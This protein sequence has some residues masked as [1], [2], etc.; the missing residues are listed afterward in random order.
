MQTQSRS[1]KHP[2]QREDVQN[3]P[4]PKTPAVREVLSWRIAQKYFLD[5]EFGHA[6]ISGQTNVLATT[7]DFAGIAFLTDRRLWSPI[8]SRLRI[9][10]SPR[11]EAEWNLDYDFKKG[12]I[13]SSTAIVSYHFGDFTVGGS[14]NLLRTLPVA[15]SKPGVKLSPMDLVRVPPP[16]TL[17]KLSPADYHQFRVLLGYGSATK[18]GWSALT[19]FGFDANAG[20]LQYG[21][22]QTTYNWNCCGVSLEYRR[23]VLSS[24]GRNENEYLF[25]FN[26]AN[27]GGFGNLR[28]QEPAF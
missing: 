26:L 10:T 17:P 9:Q 19:N 28:K 3:Q 6:L 5:P 18:R 27:L 14:D 1:A 22:A 11:S 23:I 25:R 15:L 8:I 7:T 2:W 20:Y 21:S 13:D 24:V 4:C 12:R 16:K